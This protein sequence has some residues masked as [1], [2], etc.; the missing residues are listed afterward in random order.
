M[1]AP[2]RLLLLFLL[3]LPASAQVLARPHW[4]GSGVQSQPW[5]QRAVFYR[6]HPALFQDSTGTGVG[7]LHGIAQRLDYLTRLGVDA[8]ILVP[9]FDEDSFG[10]LTLAASQ[11]HIRVLVQPASASPAEARKWLTQGA[12]GL[13][14]DGAALAAQPSA[15]DLSAVRKLADSFPGQRILITSGLAAA[16]AAQS[17]QLSVVADLTTARPDPAE[18]RS[19]LASIAANNTAPGPLLE[20]RDLP[21]PGDNPARAA[22]LDR[23]VAA[24][25]FA[26]RAA[27]LFDAGR[28]LGLR[29]PD[30]RA[31]IMQWTPGN[32]TVP[33]PQSTATA[34]EEE[35][36]AYTPY[37][38]PSR[39][40]LSAP[41]A[42]DVVENE[43]ALPSDPN[44]LPGFTTGRLP[45]HGAALNG[46]LANVA[47]EEHQPDSLLSFYR[48]LIGLHHSNPA[49]R[50]GTA[51]VFN[52]D[53]DHTVVWLRHAPEGTRTSASVVIAANPTAEPAE[54]SLRPDLASA[55]LAAP[56]TRDRASSTG[57][58]LRRLVSAPD[59]GFPLETTDSVLLPPYTVYLGELGAATA[60]SH[61]R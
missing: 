14:L 57:G 15:A 47:L 49:L 2:L 9:P 43:S 30:G 22:A 18:L 24:M 12:A 58:Y 36:H 5:F 6:I 59:I 38:P 27:V 56:H 46:A 61:R 4:A 13:F 51:T 60:A 48:V 26:S 42:P 11:A 44:T 34:P 21:T 32:R 50:N 29:S 33:Q 17:A 35:F 55:G 10:D 16:G 54:F 25:L 23:T 45:V 31:A 7:D 39:A 28:E 37:V 8:I 1:R 19:T 20:L 41:H 53:S 52:H 40:G 3:S